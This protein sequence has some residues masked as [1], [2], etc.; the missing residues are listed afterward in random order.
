[1]VIFCF[2]F[3]KRENLQKIL[4]W[5]LLHLSL[6]RWTFYYIKHKARGRLKLVTLGQNTVS[7]CV[8]PDECFAAGAL[9]TV[10][11]DILQRQ[12]EGQTLCVRD[13]QVCD[14][15]QVVHAH[16]HLVL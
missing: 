2:D 13:V 4:A 14:V 12:G 6:L 3:S 10:V 9:R 15:V 1:M 8:V 16:E 7:V 11:E 5:L